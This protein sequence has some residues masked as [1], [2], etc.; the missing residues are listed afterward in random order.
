MWGAIGTSIALLTILSPDLLPRAEQR[1]GMTLVVRLPEGKKTRLPIA[2][3]PAAPTVKGTAEVEYRGGRSRIKLTV[4][5]LPDPR[6]VGSYN[7]TYVAW[8][9]KDDHVIENLAEMPLKK[10]DGWKMKYS[11]PVYPIAEPCDNN[12]PAQQF[13]RG[14]IAP[15]YLVLPE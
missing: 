13:Q 5:N 11:N 14:E 7:T 4:E 15:L 10:A 8:V 2:G 6:R 3:T 12:L 1:S 9:V